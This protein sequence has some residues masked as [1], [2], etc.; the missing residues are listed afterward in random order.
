MYEIT[1]SKEEANESHSTEEPEF[2]M[3]ALDGI[4]TYT[5]DIDGERQQ[6]PSTNDGLRVL[7]DYLAEKSSSIFTKSPEE[8]F[9]PEYDVDPSLTINIEATIKDIAD[10]SEL[11]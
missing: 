1:L 7:D 9:L 4:R 5:L 10:E 8:A 6:I 3:Q 11:D 2:I